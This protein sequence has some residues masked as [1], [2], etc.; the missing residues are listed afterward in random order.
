MKMRCNSAFDAPRRHAAALAASCAAFALAGCVSSAGIAP[1][2]QKMSAAEVG[3]PPYAPAAAVSDRWWK[4]FGDAE[5]DKL[6]ESAFAGN[7]SLKVAR[8]RIARAA[9]ATS[10]AQA[11]FGP[12]VDADLNLQRQRYTENGLIPPPI[13]GS[14]GNTGLFQLS[15]SWEIDFF[16]KN[17]AALGAALGAQRAA[18]AD[19]QAARVLLAANVARS[20]FALGGLFEQ[21]VVA[22]RALAQRQEILALI[23]QRVEA[24]LDTNVELRQGEAAVPETARQIEV[25]DEQIAH[26]RHAL[27]ALAAQPAGALDALA[28]RLRTVRAVPLPA[29]IPADLLGRRADIEA[30]RQR[31][32]AATQDVAYSKTLLYPNVNLIAFAGLSSLGVNRLVNAGSEQ[33]GAGVA[34]HLPIFD[35]GRLRANVSAKTADLDAAIDSYNAA[36]IEAVRDAADQIASVQSIARQHTK[37]AEAQARSEQAYDLALQRFGAGLGTYLTVLSAEVE[38]LAQ[39]RRGADLKA[40]ELDSQVALA[41][42]LGGGYD[43]AA[44]NQFSNGADPAR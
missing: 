10:A 21:R 9:A 4:A 31:V 36:L 24:G 43:A 19:A 34:V 40:R 38:V 35:A 33:Y 1:Q 3:V 23:R 30:A 18:E 6:V 15:G 22:E 26:T 37:Q 8:D 12:R 29:D 16:G 2:A 11:N 13:A 41:R 7:P 42:A 44:Q 14:V 32:E 25:I 5:L 17:A 20:Y 39:R 28:P 27:T